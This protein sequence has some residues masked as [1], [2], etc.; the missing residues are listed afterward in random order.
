MNRTDQNNQYVL[1][2]ISDQKLLPGGLFTLRNA[3][4]QR[5]RMNVKTVEHLPDFR[6]IVQAQNEPGLDAL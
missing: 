1:I 5:H 3:I 2:E 6:M 4:F